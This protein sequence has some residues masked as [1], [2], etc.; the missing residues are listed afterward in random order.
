MEE[1]F[2]NAP[3]QTFALAKA[4]GEQC[5]RGEVYCL[6]GDLGAGKT[7]FAQGFGTGLGV[8]D[9]INSPTFTIV[10]VYEEGRMPLYHFDVYRIADPEEMYEVGFEEYVEGQ[11]VCL[12][13][14]S[15]LIEDILPEHRI[16][17]RIERVPGGSEEERRLRI[18][19]Y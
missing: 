14:W 6:N 11:G 7:L 19:R 12:I 10:Q 13:E 15:D 1:L 4:M 3:E 16:D 17:I 8:T 2:T 18:C 5:R 9:P